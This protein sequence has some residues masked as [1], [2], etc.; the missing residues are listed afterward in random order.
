[1]KRRREKIELEKRTLKEV[2]DEKHV[3]SMI[4]L[5]TNAKFLV[6]TEDTL[7]VRLKTDIQYHSML[8]S[9]LVPSPHSLRKF[10]KSLLVLEKCIIFQCKATENYIGIQWIHCFISRRNES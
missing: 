8:I 7:V 1:M 4:S 6:V 9:L 10:E 5:I 3:M 2:I